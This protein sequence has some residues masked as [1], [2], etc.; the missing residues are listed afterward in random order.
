MTKVGDK[1]LLSCGFRCDGF[2]FID[3][4]GA[5]AFLCGVASS[6]FVK[7]HAFSYQPRD[8]SRSKSSIQYLWRYGDLP[9][10]KMVSMVQR[11]TIQIANSAVRGGGVK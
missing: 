3:A 4:P 1:S 10:G 8:I 11:N 5:P 6:V 9:R 2:G 7:V